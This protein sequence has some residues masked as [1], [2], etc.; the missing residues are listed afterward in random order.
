MLDTLIKINI[1]YLLNRKTRNMKSIIVSA[2]IGAII[3]LIVSII[4]CII[5]KADP[6]NEI[7]FVDV[8][9]A[10]LI[11]ISYG[12]LGGIFVR[13]YHMYKEGIIPW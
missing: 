1:S 11:G 5:R 7:D 4:D 8:G 12:A 13:V 3:G 9:V 6:S 10:I 2:I